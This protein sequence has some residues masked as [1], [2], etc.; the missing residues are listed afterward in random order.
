MRTYQPKEKALFLKGK[1]GLCKLISMQ[2]SVI[3]NEGSVRIA[4]YL[5]AI[6][7]HHA[8]MLSGLPKL[9][10]SDNSIHCP[11]ESSAASNRRMDAQE[12]NQGC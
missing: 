3:K 7:L 5:S 10:I 11:Y 1:L 9:W 12:W 6:G 8:V 2:Y 4:S